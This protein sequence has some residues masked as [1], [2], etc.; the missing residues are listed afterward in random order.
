MCRRE[1]RRGFTIVELLVVVVILVIVVALLLPAIQSA[2]EAARQGQC[3]NNMMQ[4]GLAF[5]S[6]HDANKCF[7]PSSGVT[8]DANGKITA[9]DGWSCFAPLLPFIEEQ[10][11]YG[12][13]DIANG[14][15]LV[16]PAGAAGTPH[17]DAMATSLSELICP[18]F[19]GS[20]YTTVAGKK[21]AIS[22]YKAM[23]A[24]HIESLS[25]ASPQPLRPKY[26]PDGKDAQGNSI[27]PDGACFP[28][29]KL[30]IKDMAND[31]TSHTFLVVETVEPQFAR[32][33][34]GRRG[35]CGGTSAGTLKY[36]QYNNTY[37][38]PKG[39][40]GVC[41]DQADAKPPYSTYRTYLNW[42]CEKKP[43]DG[44]DGTIGGKYGPSSNHPNVVNHLR[45]D[46]SA[47]SFTK[48]FDVAAYMFMITRNGGDTYWIT[49]DPVE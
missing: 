20:P 6:Y 17:A 10:G 15:P 42:D 1:Q 30:A 48:D 36:E 22:N 3:L 18:S 49:G 43:Y 35:H 23:G 7:P 34:V 11:L 45:G 5:H 38:A 13:L 40:N 8:R 12:T 24:T 32:W 19:Q 47:R 21:A 9:V 37:Y 26:N 4:L 28:G 33:A 46:G 16:E 44:A 29:R 27:H 14:R 2:R 31:G 39:F 25:V 41:G